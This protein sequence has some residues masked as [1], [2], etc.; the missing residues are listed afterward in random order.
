M[1]ILLVDDSPTQR[2]MILS[3][4]RKA[5]V[6]ANV[7]EVSSAQEAIRELSEHY[8]EIGLI[9]CDENMPKLTGLEFA[10]AVGNI[11]ALGKTPLFLMVHEGADKKIQELM[12]T[13]PALTG[14][15]IKPFT[16]EQFKKSVMPYLHLSKMEKL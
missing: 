4:L 8:Q 5:G 2:Q 7:I 1:K 16:A 9:L 11:P 14:Y 3:V 6:T 10:S 12:A 15:L 13:T